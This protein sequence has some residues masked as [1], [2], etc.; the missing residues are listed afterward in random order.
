[1]C[2]IGTTKSHWC[3][4]LA[5]VC[6]HAVTAQ[7]PLAHSAQSAYHSHE[8]VI[9]ARP[10]QQWPESPWTMSGPCQG[11]P[12]QMEATSAPLKLLPDVTGA[13]RPAKSRFARIRATSDRDTLDAALVSRPW[14]TRVLVEHIPVHVS[15]LRELSVLDSPPQRTP[16]PIPLPPFPST[17]SALLNAAASPNFSPLTT[18]HHDAR[19]TGYDEHR[20]RHLQTTCPSAGALPQQ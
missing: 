13:F 12:H 19:G 18:E 3:T 14:S 9:N 11:A 15:Q 17:R 4:L 2:G 20:G 10:T 5:A 16:P 1:M 6:L 7:G 8:P